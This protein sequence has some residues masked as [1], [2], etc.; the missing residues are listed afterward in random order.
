MLTESLGDLEIIIEMPSPPE[1]TLVGTIRDFEDTHPDF[2]SVPIMNDPGIVLPDLGIDGLP[3]YAG[4]G[5]HPTTNGQEAFDQWYRDTPGIN[6]SMALPI[7]LTATGAPDVREYSNGSYFPVDDQLLGNQGRAHNYHFTFELHADFTY[8]GGETITVTADDDIW[9]F[10]NRH[11]AIDL[12]GVHGARTASVVLDDHAADCEIS[13]G[14][15]YAVDLF[16]AERHTVS[17]VFR[18]ETTLDLVG[19]P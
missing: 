11:L 1:I 10:V 8:H 9:V 15:T 19:R 4:Q 3:V 5:D 2:E 17:S 6:L 18:I 7:E 14:N 16:F 12:G 13:V